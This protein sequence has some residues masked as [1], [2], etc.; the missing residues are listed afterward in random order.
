MAGSA[1]VTAAAMEMEASHRPLTDV[2]DA[3]DLTLPQQERVPKDPSYV[4]R[5]PCVGSRIAI[6]VCIIY[7]LVV[8]YRVWYVYIYRHT[9]LIYY[10]SLVYLGS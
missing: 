4:C 8:M 6:F 5:A 9:L 2:E 7:V 10:I 3:A 1:A